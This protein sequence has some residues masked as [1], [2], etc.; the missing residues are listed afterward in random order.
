MFKAMRIKSIALAIALLRW[1][2]GKDFY[3][4]ESVED[5]HILLRAV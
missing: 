5:H 2:Q 1:S 3:Q 4:I